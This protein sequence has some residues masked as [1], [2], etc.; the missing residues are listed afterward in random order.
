M[1]LVTGR[2]GQGAPSPV[3]AQDYLHQPNVSHVVLS[4]NETPK[5]CSC[6]ILNYEG[7]QQGKICMNINP[8]S[9]LIILWCDAS[10]HCEESTSKFWL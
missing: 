3:Q 10:W 6:R 9:G 1:A 5:Q 4:L 7:S 2:Q 8:T